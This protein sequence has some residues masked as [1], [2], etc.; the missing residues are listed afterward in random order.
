MAYDEEQKK[1]RIVVETPAARREVVQSRI[2]RV[3][4]RNGISTGVVA[5]IVVAT[6]AL[7]TILFL[8][9]MN[10]RQDTTTVSTTQPV[11]TQPAA[12]QPV[13]V[14]QPAPQPQQQPVIIQAPPATT[15]PAPIVVAPPATSSSSTSTTTTGTTTSSVADDSAIQTA[16]DRKLSQDQTLGQLGLTAIVIDGKATLTGTVN[17]D[18]LKQQAERL[19]RS[20]RGVKAVDN[21][22]AVTAAP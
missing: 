17:S 18:A 5:A 7:C 6:V 22:I 12:Q 3:P 4:E 14:Q 19:V 8:F 9:L 15:Q 20:V 21:Q 11:A 1:S 2:E 13:I 10:G 16:I